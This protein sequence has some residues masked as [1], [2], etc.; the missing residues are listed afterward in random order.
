MKLLTSPASMPDTPNAATPRA[1][2]GPAS[3]S[4]AHPLLKDK[5][6]LLVDD[7]PGVRNSL[8]EVLVSEGCVVLPAEN[9]EQALTL[10]DATKLD[11]V[12]LDLN[13]P[14]KNGWDTFERLTAVYPLVPVI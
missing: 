7:D 2:R 9:G 13:M 3:A 1:P 10:A 6:I 14:V 11:L 8:S 5:R 12:I 4:P